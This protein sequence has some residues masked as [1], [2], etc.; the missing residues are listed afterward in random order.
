MRGICSGLW[1]GVRVWMWV[2]FGG[3]RYGEGRAAS[4][5]GGCGWRDGDWG[6]GRYGARCGRG[7][8]EV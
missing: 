6:E 4:R 1:V 8:G 7:E 2:W 5:G 3:I